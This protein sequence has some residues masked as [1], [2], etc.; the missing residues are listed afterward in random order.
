MNSAFLKEL[1]KNLDRPT[2]PVTHFPILYLTV[3]ATMTIE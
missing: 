2:L 3:F 1:E